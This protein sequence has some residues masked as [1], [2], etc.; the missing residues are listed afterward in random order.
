MSVAYEAVLD[1]SEDSVLFLAD[2]LGAERVRRGTRRDTRALSTR[3]Q[4]VLVL[5]WFLDDARMSGLAR[6]NGISSSTAYAYRDEGIAVL[7]ALVPSLHG[8]LLAA[9]IAGH[10]Y[11]IVDGTLIRTDRISTPG[12][13]VGVDLWWSGK[14]KHHG[15][16][17]QVVS[18]PDGWPL[19]TS[20]VRPGREHDMSAARAD[21]DLVAGL[22][23]WVGDGALVLADLGYEGE[24]DLVR[25]PV[26]KPAGGTS[27]VDQQAYNAIHGA[28]R[29]LGER[30]N[31][32]LKTTYKALRHYR[33]CPWRLG[34]IVGA[35]LV[36]LHRENHRTT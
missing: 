9:R 13:T 21:P 5:R 19:W 22:V 6:D 24:P 32:L 11:V 14:H 15:G 30:A 16:N 34:D 36:L 7:E 27:T 33:G 12:P 28:L 31:S 3:T 20:G 29:C 23:D 10:A 35:A 4:A 2:L 17:V 25:I 8:A 26:K 1:V 18:A